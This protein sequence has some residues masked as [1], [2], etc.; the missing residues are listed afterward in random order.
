MAKALHDAQMLPKVICGSY[1]GA[2]IAGLICSKTGEELSQVFAGNID[3][4]CFARNDTNGSSL[5][6]KIVRLLKH[7]RLFDIHVIEE[8]AKDNIGDITFKVKLV[9]D[10]VSFSNLVCCR[11]PTLKLAES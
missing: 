11:K 5:K 3:I 4:D 10:H 1:I 8:C 6:R 7:G 2:L 9:L